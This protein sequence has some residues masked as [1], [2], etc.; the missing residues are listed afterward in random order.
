MLR[1]KPKPP[2]QSQLDREAKSVEPLIPEARNGNCKHAQQ[3]AHAYSCLLKFWEQ[4]GAPPS[5]VAMRKMGF[6]ETALDYWVGLGK[7]V[8]SEEGKYIPIGGPA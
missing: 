3:R 8:K 6:S 4:H 5:H 7:V 2:S 1:T